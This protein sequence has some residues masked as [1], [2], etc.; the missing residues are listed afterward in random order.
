[1]QRVT[2]EFAPDGGFAV[3]RALCGHDEEAVTETSTAAAIA[4]LDRVLVD[5]PGVVVGPGRARELTA[6]D[7][8][9]LLTALY[10][11]TFGPR[12]ESTRECRACHE[13]FDLVFMLED[14]VAMLRESSR[15]IE[16][17]PDAG[18]RLLDGRRFRLPAG[19]DELALLG[20]D[21]A[22][23]ER[24]LLRRCVLEGSPSDA[25]ETI[26]DAME[27]AAPLLDLDLDARCPSCGENQPVHFDLQ[28]YLLSLLVQ[29]GQQ[30]IVDIHRLA[31]TYG[32]SLAEILGLS[33]VQRRALVEQIERNAPSRWGA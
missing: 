17:D 20:L 8:D 18:Y 23:A 30:R 12:V 21:P 22:E 14:L 13:L 2:L 31:G 16:P 32:W 15:R 28:H 26:F 1:M 10:R 7:R 24:Q 29:E 33:R 4:L 3:V 5:V 27:A 6:P 11:A 9:R 25:P 19:T